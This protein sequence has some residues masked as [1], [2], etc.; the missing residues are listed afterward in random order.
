MV[1]FLLCFA[2][3]WNV[4]LIALISVLFFLGVGQLIEWLLIAAAE[5]H[6][7]RTALLPVLLEGNREL[8]HGIAIFLA[9]VWP[10]TALMAYR[11]FR[12]LHPLFVRGGKDAVALYWMTTNYHQGC[13]AAGFRVA[14]IL[15]RSSAAE[16]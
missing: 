15:S 10:A 5:G 12:I 13:P 1:P 3:L 14:V 16:T 8:F 2:A 6:P 9:C 4:A 7:V 11:V